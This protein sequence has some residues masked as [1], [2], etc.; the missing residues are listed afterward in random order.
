MYVFILKGFFLTG[1]NRK[2]RI[3]LTK[4]LSKWRKLYISPTAVMKQMNQLEAHIGLPLFV[5]TS[6]GAVLTS[7]GESVYRDAAEIIKQSGEAVWRAY[8]AEKIDQVL[9]RVG[10]SVLYPCNVLMELWNKVSSQYLQFK[11][12]VVPFEDTS[13]ENG[14]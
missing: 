4:S 7:A 8:K 10:T 1:K 14:L 2:V 13:M 5:R 11:L 9:I 6:K 12:R 3:A